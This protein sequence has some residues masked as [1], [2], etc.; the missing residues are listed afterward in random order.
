[1]AN[2]TLTVAE[3][4]IWPMDIVSPGESEPALLAWTPF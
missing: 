1:M 4:L 2:D 3:T